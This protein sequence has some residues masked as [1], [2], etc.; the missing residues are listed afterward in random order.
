MTT[1]LLTFLGTSEY[2]TVKYQI[3]GKT[4]ETHFIQEALIKHIL[5]SS[6]M[7]EKIQIVLLLTEGAKLR[8]Y[9]GDGIK[10]KN[11][12]YT[13]LKEILNKYQDKLDII[14][15]D[16]P[17]GKSEDEI[18]KIFDIIV[19]H[20]EEG[21]R[22]YLDIT[23]GFRSLPLMSTAIINYV[24]QILKDFCLEEIFY[25]AFEA[26]NQK[27]EAPIFKLKQFYILQ[28][29]TIA[30]DKFLT[31]GQDDI[32]GLIDS[33]IRQLKKKYQNTDPLLDVLRRLKNDLEIFMA[34]I[35]TNRT[36]DSIKYA[37]KIKIHFKHMEGLPGNDYVGLRPF[38]N[39][40]GKIREMVDGFREDDLVW[41]T[42]LLT[43]LCF[44]FGMYQQVYTLLGENG[45][46]C[47]LIL[48]KAP[49]SD[50]HDVNARDKIRKDYFERYKLRTMNESVMYLEEKYFH[51]KYANFFKNDFRN[52][53]NHAGMGKDPKD[54][55][56][57]VSNSK[58]QIDNF[59]LL[60]LNDDIC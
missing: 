57:I 22:V 11:P 35:K 2:K 56:S 24:G 39:I 47:L 50:F 25:G 53:V 41:N 42:H 14:S 48:G 44:G 8:N 15:V 6:K 7:E 52:D 17:E 34:S 36:Q 38:L 37:L 54:W 12:D 31:G 4:Y 13:F 18:W 23:H 28:Q 40:L 30:I 51:Q 49:K 58:K 60:F 10:R 16:V 33:E 29:W 21:D 1:K 5:S 43:K 59:E 3:D 26:K 27:S 19:N 45:T 55:E 32:I 9:L 20:L 46:N